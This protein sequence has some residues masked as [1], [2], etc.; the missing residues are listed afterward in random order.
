MTDDK[1]TFRKLT[2]I[3]KEEVIRHWQLGTGSREELAKKYNVSGSTIART[4][5]G[6]KYGEA[7]DEIRELADETTAADAKDYAEM[8]KLRLDKTREEAFKRADTLARILFREIGKTL[9]DDVNFSDVAPDLK[10]IKMAA[11]TN[12]L[13]RREMY[14]IL[15]I[16]PKEIDPKELPEL[17]FRIVSDEDIQARAQREAEL[18]NADIEMP[19]DDEKIVYDEDD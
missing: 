11:E 2:P 5:K 17:V 1:K 19:A 4:V 16:N 12:Q 14:E 13:L 18:F 3:E 8:R 9:T 6:I 15:G 10:A 7:E